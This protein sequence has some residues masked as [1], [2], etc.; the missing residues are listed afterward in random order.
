MDGVSHFFFSYSW[1]PTLQVFQKNIWCENFH[2]NIVWAAFG[3]S[4]S[5]SLPEFCSRGN[6]RTDALVHFWKFLLLMQLKIT[7]YQKILH[8]L[9]ARI[10]DSRWCFH[11]WCI[12]PGVPAVWSLP[13]Y[14]GAVPNP[15]SP[16]LN[17]PTATALEKS[18]TNSFSD[19]RILPNLVL[20]SF[21]YR[22]HTVRANSNTFCSTRN[23]LAC[24]PL[25][26]S[27][28]TYFQQD[29]FK[30]THPVP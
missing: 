17:T 18:P 26:R 23:I 7:H 10:L 16:N 22:S 19:T 2:S 11:W 5:K 4:V 29:L 3:K 25:I 1:M 14:Q 6:W 21:F 9:Q 30:F 13:Q 20:P 28:W 27:P 8:C 12:L 24:Q 15:F